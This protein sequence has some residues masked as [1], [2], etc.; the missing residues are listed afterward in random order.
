MNRA[1][2][3]LAAATLASSSFATTIFDGIGTGNTM[4]GYTLGGLYPNVSG[5]DISGAAA[6][7]VISGL[8]VNVGAS[9]V[10]TYTGLELIVNIYDTY[11]GG[12]TGS[13]PEFSNLLSTT[14][15]TLPG[16]TSALNTYYP[17]TALALNPATISGSSFGATI[18]ILANTGSGYAAATNLQTVLTVVAPAVGSN[19]LGGTIFGTT[20]ATN[21]TVLTGSNSVSF[22]SGFPNVNLAATFTGTTPAPEPVSIAFLSLGVVGLIARRRGRG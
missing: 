22:G 12:T 13:T 21:S 15:I 16:F 17:Q 20:V 4:Y 5:E 9:S 7:D 1:I 18:L 6:G 10:T 3:T 2:L 14:T 11:T 8:T 19:A